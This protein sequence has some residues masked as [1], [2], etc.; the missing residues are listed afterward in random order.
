MAKYQ[1]EKITLSNKFVA[2]RLNHA[3]SLFLLLLLACQSRDIQPKG[4]G[5]QYF[6]LKVGA[7]WIYAVVE[8]TITQLGG[9]TNTMYELKLQL[10]D[11]A[12]TS[13]AITYVMQRF[14][15][16]DASQS[17]SSIGTWSARKEP[18][19]AIVQE[20]N[21]P[22]VKIAFPL[23]EGKTWDGNALNNLGGTDRCPNGTFRCDNYQSIDLA[24]RFEGSGVSYD[25]SVTILENNDND[26]IV[27]QDVRKSTYAKSIG[28]VYR[29]ITILE[30]CTIGNCIGKQIVEN[31]TILKQTLNNYGGL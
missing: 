25:D 15:R 19:Q 22:Y 24:K 31:G 26:P 11:S 7:F 20:G 30:Y 16:T 18:F 28:L 29:E 10:T 6:P 1:K 21:I 12:T 17:W 5:T 2:V 9:Q 8:T 13:G 14:K 23:T 27:K 3:I 4:T